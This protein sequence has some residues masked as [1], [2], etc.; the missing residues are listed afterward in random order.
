MSSRTTSYP[1][2]CQRRQHGTDA[3]AD[4]EVKRAGITIR[5]CRLPRHFVAPLPVQ[6]FAATASGNRWGVAASVTYAGLWL[7]ND[8]R[9]F[10]EKRLRAHAA[11]FEVERV[12]HLA[13]VI[14]IARGARLLPLYKQALANLRTDANDA[15]TRRSR[16][17]R[18][19]TAAAHRPP[20]P[21][22]KR[23]CG[24]STNFDQRARVSTSQRH[25]QHSRE[26]GDNESVA[27]LWCAVHRLI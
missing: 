17:S 7:A 14:Q 11:Y 25:K 23:S 5:G 2:W 3:A 24:S 22:G 15:W 16:S 4:A 18:S 9:S 6:L 19:T 1:C 13:R 20:M 26:R 27:Y 8:E 21:K 12:Q 10:S